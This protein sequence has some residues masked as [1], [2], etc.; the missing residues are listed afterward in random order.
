MTTTNTKETSKKGAN[1][2]D[3]KNDEYWVTTL[4]KAVSSWYVRRENHFYSVRNPSSSINQSD[5]QR[6]CLFRIRDEFPEFEFDKEVLKRV[7]SKSIEARHTD[8]ERSIPVW[9]RS[10]VC[11]PDVDSR[12]VW[13]EGTVSLNA[14]H[15]P[16]Y[17]TGETDDGKPGV[18]VELLNQMFPREEDR[19]VFTNWLA[20]CLQNEADK[21][22]WAPFL[23]SRAKG[24]GKSTLCTL[25]T[26]LFGRENSMVLNNVSEVTA[27]FNMPIL[28]SKLVVCEELQLRPDSKEGN[29]LKTY[30]TET[31]TSSE[32]KGRDIERIKQCCCFLFTSN[33]LPIWIEADER[34]YFVIDVDHSG[35]ASGDDAREFGDLVKKV[36]DFMSNPA[37]LRGLY[38]WLMERRIPNSFNAKSLNS[39]ELTSPIMERI[40]GASRQ[41]LSQQLEEILN[42]RKVF[43]ISQNDLMTVF[44]ERLKANTGRIRHLMTELGWTSVTAKWGGKDYGRAAWVHPHYQLVRG[45][46]LGPRGYHESMKSEGDDFEVTPFEFNDDEGSD[47]STLDDVIERAA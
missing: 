36:H 45:K 5:L 12:V 22:M 30:L 6:A 33:H 29:R 17:R 9:G 37:E 39:T 13:E 3:P 35:H 15:R 21:P 44:V 41:V 46:V 4:S 31:E 23:Y 32:A 1:S 18:Y 42:E 28:L 10:Q 47:L 25:V 20:W 38:R 8:Q 7:F 16:E 43:A 11:Q 26:A 19:E 40:Q 24:T 2:E 27:K 14:W 34:R